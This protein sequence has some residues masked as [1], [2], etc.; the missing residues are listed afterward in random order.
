MEVS[1]QLLWKEVFL[2]G[3]AGPYLLKDEVTWDG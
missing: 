2:R 1:R 3:I